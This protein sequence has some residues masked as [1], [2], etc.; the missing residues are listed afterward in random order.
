VPA[1]AAA[2]A[3]DGGSAIRREQKLDGTWHTQVG[4]T[5]LRL[6]PVAAPP[7]STLTQQAAAAV[8]EAGGGQDRSELLAQLAAVERR[9]EETTGRLGEAVG[10][11]LEAR[12]REDHGWQVVRTRLGCGTQH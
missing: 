10:R 5:Q 4:S 3:G 7:G 11:M 6:D 8:P 9:L 1:A 2:A 12:A